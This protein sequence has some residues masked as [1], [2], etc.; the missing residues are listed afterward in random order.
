MIITEKRA[1][2]QRRQAGSGMPWVYWEERMKSSLQKLPLNFVTLGN[3]IIDAF[4][5]HNRVEN[6]LYDTEKDYIMKGFKHLKSK[7]RD[8]LAYFIQAGIFPSSEAILNLERLLSRGE[9]AFC[10]GRSSGIIKI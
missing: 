10:L 7:E 4:D 9:L 5:W 8:N 3:L 2:L 1:P 6:L